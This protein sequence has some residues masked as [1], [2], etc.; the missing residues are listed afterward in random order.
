MKRIPLLAAAAA[1]SLTLLCGGAF[2][3]AEL[4]P[5]F[6]ILPKPKSVR[7]GEGRGLAAFGLRSLALEPGTERPVVLPPLLEV[8]PVG[9]G[10]GEGVLTLALV[11]GDPAPDNF[12]GY[13][14]DVSNG[15]ARVVAR[16]EAGLFYGCQTLQQLLEDARDTGAEIP[17]LR[18]VDWPDIGYRAVHFDVK[19][20][21]D[22]MEYYYDAIDRLAAMKINAV[23]FELEDKLRYRRQP[24]VGAGN[25]M[26]IEEVAALT[27]YARDRHVEISPLIQGLGHAAFILKHDEYRDIRDDESRDWAFCPLKERTYEVQFDLYLDAIEATPGSRYL[28]IGGDEVSVGA[29]EECKATGLSSFELQ[30]KWLRRVSDFAAEHNRIPIMWDDMPLEHAG[31][32][33]TTH[34]DLD[35]EEVERIWSENG[36]NLDGS[37]NLFPKNCIYMR[38]N[39]GAPTV[40]GNIRTLEWYQQNGLSAMAATAAQT[41]W[42]IHPRNGGNAVPIRDFNRLTAN[43]EL[44]G[45]LCTAWDDSSPHMEF[46]W[47]GWSAHAEYAWSPEGRSIE[48]FNAAYGQRRFGPA[49]RELASRIHD[50]LEAALNAGD[51]ILRDRPG[52]RGPFRPGEELG[53]ALKLP[54]SGAPGQWSRRN[55][56]RLETARGE[57]E[58]YN[59]LMRDFDDLM[60]A[61]TRGRFALRLMSALSEVQACSWRLLLATAEC[62]QKG[63]EAAGP[64]LRAEIER[65][66]EAQAHFLDVFS[67]TRFLNNP[68]GYQLDQNYHP[69]LANVRNDPSWIFALESGYCANARAWLNRNL[70][71]KPPAQRL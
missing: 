51:T 54:D 27:R 70:A 41:T 34:R 49:G 42:P 48:D 53:A 40:E 58:R 69:H 71:A 5:E 25:A 45:I 44:D 7:V 30:M 65:F 50:G 9:E 57:L 10:E 19:H 12:E 24:I 63:L 38:W 26:S 18:I 31:V 46:Y 28:H 14:L 13:L 60:N 21:L 67:E 68:P 29:C 6:Q 62:D 23:I 2:T 47:R 4:P 8:L 20:H 35:H 66:E 33:Q 52:R 11:D 64:K 55:A 61:A 16:S 15:L 59:N 43:Y 32:Y 22:R 56:P 17:A 39:Y 36:K 3:Q 37:I 1:A